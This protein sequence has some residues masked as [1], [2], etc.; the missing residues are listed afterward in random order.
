MPSGRIL[1]IA[2][3][4]DLRGSMAFAL[5]AEGFEVSGRDELPDYSWVARQGYDCTVLDQRALQGAD[6]ES[7]AFCVKAYPVVLLAAR[8]HSWL[9]EWVTDIV[10]MPVIGNAISDAVQHALQLKGAAN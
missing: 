4:P 2:P 9:V 5:E 7:I 8:P 3:N 6:Y 10:D 1:I